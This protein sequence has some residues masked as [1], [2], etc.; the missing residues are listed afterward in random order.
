MIFNRCTAIAGLAV[1]FIPQIAVASFITLLGKPTVTFVANGDSIEVSG[2]YEIGNSGDE[3]AFDVFP[4]LRVGSWAWSGAPRDIAPNQKESWEIKSL[5]KPS[6]IKCLSADW[7]AGLDLPVRGIF[8]MLIQRNYR[9]TNAAPFSA[10]DVAVVTIGEMADGELALAQS[11]AMKAKFVCSAEGGDFDCEVNLL[12]S[13]DSA[14]KVAVS[15]HT[16]KELLVTGPPK[17]VDLAPSGEAS[18]HI[19]LR[20]LAGP[21][22]S[23]YAVFA[24]I[25]WDENGIRKSMSLL[26]HV[27]IVRLTEI[28]NYVVAGILALIT[29]AALLYGFVFRRR[30]A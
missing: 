19:K 27:K 7:C 29:L 17:A 23:T 11:T 24:V 26:Q 15:Y 5:L 4:L 22:G 28:T 2:S 3:T 6:D 18:T 13:S 12:N 20:N 21:T 10:A 16:T 8:P 25:Q 14:K 1:L 9:D 30:Q